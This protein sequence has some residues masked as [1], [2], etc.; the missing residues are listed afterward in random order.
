MFAGRRVDII[1]NG[2]LKIQYNRNRHYD[3]YTGRWLTHDS[4]GINPAGGMHKPLYPGGQYW[5]GLAL[6][7]YVR[8][9]P[10]TNVDV[11]GYVT[12]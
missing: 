7:E 9:R 12:F 8:N 3:Y 11:N 1:D 4:L 2:F 5:D 10:T 6:H